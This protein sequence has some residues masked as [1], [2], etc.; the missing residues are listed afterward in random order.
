ML[1]KPVLWMGSSRE[2]LIA[3]PA[4][5]RRD[6]G[7]QLDKLQRGGDPSDWKPMPAVGP[8]VREIRLHEGSG[9]FRVLFARRPEGI[10]VL[11]CFGKKSQKT[12]QQDLSLA[13]RRFRA[14]PRS[15]DAR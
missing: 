11:H 8:G 9:E 6:A 12:S 13:V 4:D 2:D 5:A 15:G 1:I 14:I 10:Y 7:Y 3:F